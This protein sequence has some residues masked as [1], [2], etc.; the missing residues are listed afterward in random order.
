MW[1]DTITKR[2]MVVA[3]QKKSTSSLAVFYFNTFYTLNQNTVSMQT[4]KSEGSLLIYITAPDP[5]FRL[6]KPLDEHDS[7]TVSILWSRGSECQP[8][9]QYRFFFKSLG[10]YF[11]ITVH[12]C[13][14]WNTTCNLS[15]TLSFTVP[16]APP[17]AS[18]L[19]SCLCPNQVTHIFT[20]LTRLQVYDMFSVSV[21]I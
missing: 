13:R 5:C 3:L 6:L 10:N 7:Q 8:F 15:K 16:C 4:R 20:H 9:L 2:N 11:M 14:E 1:N 17:D 18:S 12:H 19:E 21:S